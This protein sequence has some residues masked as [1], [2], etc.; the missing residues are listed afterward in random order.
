MMEQISCHYTNQ[1]VPKLYRSMILSA[2]YKPRSQDN[3]LR[4]RCHTV[5]I[6][7]TLWHLS[8]LVSDNTKLNQG[9][10]HR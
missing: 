4:F 5:I 10:T 6:V 3:P 1:Y 8:I 2:S 9:Y 7:S